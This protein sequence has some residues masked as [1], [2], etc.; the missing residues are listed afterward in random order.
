M[1]KLELSISPTVFHFNYKGHR[2]FLTL[3]LLIKAEI[4]TAE[5]VSLIVAMIPF[6]KRY[7]SSFSLRNLKNLMFLNL[8]KRN[9]STN[10]TGKI[11]IDRIEEPK[12]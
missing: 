7:F 8:E 10:K 11:T 12:L 2:N 1:P 5:K 9:H 3:S 6:Q 4:I